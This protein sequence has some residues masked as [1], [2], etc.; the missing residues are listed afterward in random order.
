MADNNSKVMKG[1]AQAVEDETAAAEHNKRI[2]EDATEELRLEHNAYVAKKAEE[3][4]AKLGKLAMYEEDLVS[5][6]LSCS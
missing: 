6:W 4:Q 2:C 1:I 3:L 5:P